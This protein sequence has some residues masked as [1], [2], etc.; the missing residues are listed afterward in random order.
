[1]TKENERVM[2]CVCNS[3]IKWE[4]VFFNFIRWFNK[5]KKKDNRTVELTLEELKNIIGLPQEYIINLDGFKSKLY[6]MC[7][8]KGLELH[9]RGDNYFRIAN[10][11]KFTDLKSIEKFVEKKERENNDKLKLEKAVLHIKESLDKSEIN[12][13]MIYSEDLMKDLEELNNIRMVIEYMKRKMKK[14][15]IVIRLDH[16]HEKEVI[17]FSYDT[18]W[19][20]LGFLSKEQYDNF[21][22][23]YIDDYEDSEDSGNRDCKSIKK[24]IEELKKDPESLFNNSEFV[25]KIR[26]L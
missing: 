18:D 22:L 24:S 3:Y 23:V 11:D 10:I 15:D 25:K 6:G 2:S 14:Y 8:K 13:V 16:D 5:V 4:Y 1:M 21:K 26:K 17:V 20:K 19:K 7:I 9:T 12:S